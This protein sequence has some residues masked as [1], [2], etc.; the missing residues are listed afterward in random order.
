MPNGYTLAD[1]AI[2]APVLLPSIKS[3]T[4][5]QKCR[6][7]K[8]INVETCWGVTIGHLARFTEPKMVRICNFVRVGIGPLSKK[9]AVKNQIQARSLRQYSAIEKKVSPGQVENSY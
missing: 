8:G 3:T 6:Q 9:L 7:M 2:G 5:N 4:Q 1:F